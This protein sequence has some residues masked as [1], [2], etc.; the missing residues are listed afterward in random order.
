MDGTAARRRGEV[1]RSVGFGKYTDV[2]GADNINKGS[3][4]KKKK[5]AT[6]TKTK[7]TK[8]TRRDRTRG[9]EKKKERKNDFE[10][11]SLP[12]GNRPLLC[13]RLTRKK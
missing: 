5:K 9:R 10:Q 2:K 13:C 4:G 12:Y 11:D 1:D 6:T 8:Q 7:P 3:R